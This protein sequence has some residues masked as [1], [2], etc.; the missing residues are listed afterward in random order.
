MTVHALKSVTVAL[1]AFA[2]ALPTQ[3]LASA[4]ASEKTAGLWQPAPTPPPIVSEKLAGLW[5]P[6][7]TPPPIV[8]EK[9]AGLWQPAPPTVATAGGGFDW[10]RA[11]IGAG[12]AFGSILTAAAGGLAIQRRRSSLAHQ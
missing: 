7:P 6:A 2:A 3:A 9:L 10:G 11:G 8:S 5:Q 12:L 4:R 1:A